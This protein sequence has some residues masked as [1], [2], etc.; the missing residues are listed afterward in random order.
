MGQGQIAEPPPQWEGC[1]QSQ[2]V[3]VR[4]LSYSLLEQE[5]CNVIEIV[6]VSRYQKITAITKKNGSENWRDCTGV[7]V[8]A[9]LAHSQH[10]V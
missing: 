3:L 6:M 5:D 2:R 10:P 9:C 8:L 7:K 4:G 1:R